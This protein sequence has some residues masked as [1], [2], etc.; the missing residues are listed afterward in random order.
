MKGQIM[1]LSTVR[2][3][4]VENQALVF[5]TVK[6]MLEQEGWEVDYARNMIG[7]LQKI[8][9]EEE[10][11]DLIILD[12]KLRGGRGLELLRRVRELPYRRRT[13]VLMFTSEECSSEALSA[14]ADAYRPQPEGIRSIT[15][16]I[17]RLLKARKVSLSRNVH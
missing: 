9:R 1:A 15:A 14:G 3:L 8:E 7:A 13:P 5:L 12:S 4:Y 16:T 17:R 6:Q 10:R 11:Y 2:I